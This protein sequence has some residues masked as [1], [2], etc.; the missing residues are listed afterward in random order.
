MDIDC[1]PSDFPAST[2]TGLS[3]NSQR[4]TERARF[5]DFE[6]LGVIGRGGMAAVALAR[7][8]K[9]LGLPDLVALKFLNPQHLGDPDAVDA[10]EQEAHIGSLLRHPCLCRTYGTHRVG[11]R[12]AIILEHVPGYS[13]SRAHRALTALGT[14]WEQSVAVARLGLCIAT[15]LRTI[16]EARDEL[17]VTLGAVHRDVSPQNILLTPDGGVKLIDFGVMFSPHRRLKTRTGIIKG[18][19]A[20]MAPEYL[21]AKSWNHQADLWSLGVLLWEMVA[22]K[23]LFPSSDSAQFMRAVNSAPIPALT[24]RCPQ[25]APQ[26]SKIVRGAL[27]RSLALRYQDARSLASDLKEYLSRECDDQGQEVLS[28]VLGRLVGVETSSPA[29][30]DDVT[31]TQRNFPVS[32]ASDGASQA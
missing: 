25:V 4:N 5:G 15:A 16:H 14:P 11:Q 26:L 22:G 17:G 28:R 32:V 12:T 9:D 1:N 24:S 6:V 7:A 31:L 29:R 10:F 21:Q 30:R 27:Q 19:L 13:L 3:P 20:Y 23:R 18:K 2:R 8:P